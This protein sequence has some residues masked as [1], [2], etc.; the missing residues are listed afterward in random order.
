MRPLVMRAASAV[1]HHHI[2]AAAAMAQLA[3]LRARL[4]ALLANRG[5]SLAATAS[6]QGSPQA[7][8]ALPAREP[9]QAAAQ[10][11]ILARRGGP[12][13]KPPEAITDPGPLEPAAA[14]DWDA[15]RPADQGFDRVPA[16]TAPASPARLADDVREA[17]RVAA[18]ALAALGEP[19]DVEGLR[20]HS[21]CVFAPLPG[22]LT[23]CG[24]ASCVHRPGLELRSTERL[25]W[26]GWLL[27]M[28]PCA[29]GR[30]CASR[31]RCVLA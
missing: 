11:R 23:G 16:P 8:A 24:F 29:H 6:V 12:P 5:P 28:W 10:P 31:N 13:S 7:T 15:G 14:A 22:L 3:E 18:R 4:G 19:D 17:L 27:C 1:G 25:L 26:S 2:A 20:V 21:A 9:S 30:L